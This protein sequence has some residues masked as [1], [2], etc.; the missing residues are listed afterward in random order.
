MRPLSSPPYFYGLIFPG[1]SDCEFGLEAPAAPRKG[2]RNANRP[3]CDISA[4]K[5]DLSAEIQ[6]GLGLAKGQRNRLQVMNLLV[7]T[8]SLKRGARGW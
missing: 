8:P 2:Q 7:A 4:D 3:T 1:S 5:D 6:N